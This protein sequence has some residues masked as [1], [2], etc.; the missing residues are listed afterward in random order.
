MKKRSTVILAAVIFAIVLLIVGKFIAKKFG[1]SDKESKVNRFPIEVATVTPTDYD[2]TLELSGTMIAENQIEVPSKVSGKIIKYLHEE[3]VWVES[4]QSV[5]SID[6]DEIGVEFKEA[7]L[8]SPIAGWLT[9][10]YFDTGARV[11]PGTPLFQVAD[12]RRIKLAVSVPESDMSKVKAGAKVAVSIDAWPDINFTGYVKKIS[13]TVD[14][15]SR[16]VKAEIS[17]GN[18][19]LKLRPGMYGRAIIN[20]KHFN[21]GI[22]IPTSAIIERESGKLAFVLNNDKASARKIE[23]GLDM[24]DRSAIKSGL[25]LGDKLIIA[26][27]HSVTDGALVEVV[28][29]E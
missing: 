8:E 1:S 15:I 13:P 12:Y 4:G 18:E 17:V 22:V 2:E 19:G 3:G 10:R 6:R 21:Q 5:V 14:Y 24:G 7:I 16:T 23:V 20:V 27:Q 26:G 25:S 11:N 29:G 9:K 28:G